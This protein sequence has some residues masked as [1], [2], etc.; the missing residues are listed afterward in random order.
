MSKRLRLPIALT[1]A[2][3]D[4]GGGAGIQADL[5]TFASLGVHG[6]SAI[7]CI[8]AQNP[9]GVLGIQ[10]CRPDIVRQQ[11]EAVFAEWQRHAVW[12]DDTTEVALWNIR[13]KAFTDFYEV[14]RLGD[15][16]YFRTIPKLT[17]RVLTHG[18]PLPES[19]LQFTE[20]EE[21]YQE[22]REHGRSERPASQDLRPRIQTTPIDPTI[23]PSSSSKAGFA[24]KFEVPAAPPGV[25]R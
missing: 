11:I 22:W 13:E 23:T 20:T 3:S 19:P 25:I 24:P 14:R 8:T 12:S 18:K 7:T 10:A 4:S 15:A 6:T 5:K 17:R 9:R 1:I 16:L 21:Q 2:G